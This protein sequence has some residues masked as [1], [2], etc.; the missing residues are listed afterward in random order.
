MKTLPDAVKRAL[1]AL[2]LC[3]ATSPALVEAGVDGVVESREAAQCMR[4]VRA[5]EEATMVVLILA[6]RALR[7]PSRADQFLM[8]ATWD[9]TSWRF[10]WPAPL[11]PPEI[12]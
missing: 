2:A 3:D 5:T 4:V 8:L 1:E 11:G 7:R 10:T 12:H 9:G 6:P